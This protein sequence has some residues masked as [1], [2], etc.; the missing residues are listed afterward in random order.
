MKRLLILLCL[1]A[2]LTV[3]G[4]DLQVGTNQVA[5]LAD[6]LSASNV[7]RQ[8]IDAIETG[9]EV[10]ME[11]LNTASN[12][13]YAVA[14]NATNALALKLVNDIYTVSNLLYNSYALLP[15]LSQLYTNASGFGIKEFAVA[16]NFSARGLIVPNATPSKVAIFDGIRFVTNS[17]LNADILTNLADVIE[18]I[19]GALA[20]KA[21]LSALQGATNELWQFLQGEWVELTDPDT[22]DL[23]IPR[24]IITLTTGFS[25]N[26][27]NTYNGAAS[28]I[29]FKVATVQEITFEDVHFPEFPEGITNSWNG[30]N[31][32]VFAVIGEGQELVGFLSGL[33]GPT[34][35][36]SDIAQATNDLATVQTAAL[37]TASNA[38]RTAASLFTNALATVQTAALNTASNALTASRVAS[39]SGSATGLTVRALT[40]ASNVVWTGSRPAAVSAATNFVLNFAPQAAG[41]LIFDEQNSTSIVNIVHGTN[42]SGGGRYITATFVSGNTNKLISWPDQLRTNILGTNF[43]INQVWMPSNK[44]GKIT[45]DN[46]LGA[47]AFVTFNYPV[48]GP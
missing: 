38:V 4:A 1:F 37:N 45:W 24:Q 44:V 40:I 7:L 23:A 32:F 46:A 20:L 9:G 30:T 22:I 29:Y 47:A 48:W 11:Q 2:S 42:F 33:A 39:S 17:P 12:V 6:F 21:P 14:V 3:R 41:D 18:P 36:A 43:L 13:V 35:T 8:A 31:L 19:G 10:T 15:N 25:P 34:V 28:S 26:F 27:G 5:W 16:T